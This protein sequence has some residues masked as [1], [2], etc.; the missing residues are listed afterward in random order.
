M[1][2]RPVQKGGGCRE[3]RRLFGLLLLLMGCGLCGETSGAIITPWD[4]FLRVRC[5]CKAST[6]SFI[7]RAVTF[8]RHVLVI[9]KSLV[10]IW[11]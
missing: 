11:F 10:L 2:S 9:A 3:I 8:F 6:V 1:W 7:P 5:A 4:L